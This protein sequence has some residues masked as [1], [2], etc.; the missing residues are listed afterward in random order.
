MVRLKVLGK[1]AEIIV[2]IIFQFQY[3]AIKSH[4]SYTYFN[5]F[6]YFNSSM[7]RLKDMEKGTTL[8]KHIFQFQYGAI[9]SSQDFGGS[10]GVD[11]SIPV[12]C[13]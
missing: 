13:D 3:G 4:K 9:K 1:V 6:L 5:L 2:V 12:W 7:V 8:K 10:V 11:I